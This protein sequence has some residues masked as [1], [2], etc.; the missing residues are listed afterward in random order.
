MKTFSKQNQVFWIG[1]LLA[2]PAVYF[3]LINVLNELGYTYLFDSSWPTL[4]RWGVQESLGWNI[5]LL[6]LFGPVIALIANLLVIIH[7]HVDSFEQRIDLYIS[8]TKRWWNLAVVL[9]CGSVLCMLALYL[10]LENYHCWGR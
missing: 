1:A 2:L 7:M 5:N 8:V 3:I 4:Q 6:I 9:L 10:F